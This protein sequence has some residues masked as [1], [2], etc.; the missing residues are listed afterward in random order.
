MVHAGEFGR[1]LVD[2][3]LGDGALHHERVLR[4]VWL[5]DDH[6]VEVDLPAL[7]VKLEELGCV[8][9]EWTRAVTELGIVVCLC[10]CECMDEKHGLGER[11]RM[12][13]EI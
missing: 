13:L 3:D 2:D 1:R 7:W 4:R 6:T 11:Y 8:F 10:V 5:L 9:R 12:P